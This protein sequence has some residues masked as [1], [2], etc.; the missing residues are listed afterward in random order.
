MC[1]SECVF[2]SVC[3]CAV[4][5]GGQFG[6]GDGVEVEVRCVCMHPCVSDDGACRWKAVPTCAREPFCNH[7]KLI[8]PYS[9]N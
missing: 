8:A 6:V 1:I 5:A 9:R 4:G 7:H 2:M 3:T